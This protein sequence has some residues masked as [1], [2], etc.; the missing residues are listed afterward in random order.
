MAR[1]K[2]IATKTKTTVYFHWHQPESG[3][4]VRRDASP[5][6]VTTNIFRASEQFWHE[7]CKNLFL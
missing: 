2:H 5:D 1:A 6:A 7:P 3:Y 4:T